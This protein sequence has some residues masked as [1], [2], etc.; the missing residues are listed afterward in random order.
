MA[1]ATGRKDRQ[2][3]KEVAASAG[4][5][6]WPHRPGEC[7]DQTLVAGT[8][9]VDGCDY[10]PAADR[11]CLDAFGTYTD[12]CTETDAEAIVC[13]QVFTCR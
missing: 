12:S 13:S 1:A 8:A 7:I 11:L 4:R 6:R 3:G 2:R 5:T 9:A 10:D